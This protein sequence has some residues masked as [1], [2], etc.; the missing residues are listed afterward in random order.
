[1]SRTNSESRDTAFAEGVCIQALAIGCSAGG[2]EALKTL[3]KILP[4]ELTMAII[5]VAHA[6]PDGAHLLPALLSKFCRLPVTEAMERESIRPGRVY[7]APPNYHLL[8]EPDRAFALSVDER[9]CF[10]RPS[11]DVFLT[12][13][14]DVYRQH[15]LAIILT[16]ANADGAEG[17]KAVK[18]GGGLVWAQD[19]ASAYAAIMP[20]AA[21]ASGAVDRILALDNM[22][23]PLQ[24]LCR[25]RKTC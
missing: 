22:A 25:V 19:P 20:E 24:D 9:V 18:A 4:A 6:S 21:V 12:S 10:V 3:L 17:V 7:V 5:I 23:L 16:G 13:A 1:M 2:F 15:L 11:V 14:A 8:V